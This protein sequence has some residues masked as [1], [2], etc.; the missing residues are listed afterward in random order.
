[1]DESNGHVTQRAIAEIMRHG[2]VEAVDELFASDFAGHDTAGGTFDREE[3]K[4]GVRAMLAA[5][6]DRE[7]SIADQIVAG[8]KVATRWIATGTHSGALN[9]IPATGRRVNLTGISIDR[10]AAGKIVESWEVTD[11]SGLL[12]QLGVLPLA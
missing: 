1:M 9:G 8:D 10:L 4:Q 11:D 5:F 7:V 2:N 3:F 12:R 6:S